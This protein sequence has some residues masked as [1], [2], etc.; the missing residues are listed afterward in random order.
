MLNKDL[1]TPKPIAL[2]DCRLVLSLHHLAGSSLAPRIL[3]ALDWPAASDLRS[4]AHLALLVP[5]PQLRLLP[6]DAAHMVAFVPSFASAAVL[7]APAVALLQQLPLHD[8]HA[9]QAYAGAVTALDQLGLLVALPAV[10]LPT[11]PASEVLTA[12]MHLTNA[13]NL[14]CTYCYIEK[15]AERMDVATARLALDAVVRAAIRYGYPEIALKY[16]GGEPLLALD[17]LETLHRYAQERTAEADLGL[18]AVV[19]S[20][21]LALSDA[22]VARLCDLD[23]GLTVSLD[24]L[25]SA[26]D[27]QRPTCGGGPSA[28]RVRAGLLRAQV[29]GLAPSAAITVSAASAAALPNLAE[30]LLAQDIPF[31][32]SFARG[33]GCGGYGVDPVAEGEQIIAAMRE[34]Y[35]V[36]AHHPPRWSVLGALIDRSDLSHPHSHACAV[37]ES[38]LVIDPHGQVAKCQM[39]IAQPVSTI[40]ASDPLGDLRHDPQGVQRIPV[41]VKHECRTCE[42]RYWCSGGCPIA[43]YQAT[44]RYD[45]KSP[46]CGIY[47]ALYPDL[48]RLEGLRLLHW[49]GR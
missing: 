4:L 15:S 10:D 17:T 16:A 28:A 9:L 30:W 24:G 42:W 36:V 34:L 2:N 14:R 5:H 47:K 11:P 1:Q 38:Y 44:G 26:H 12:W 43:T 6:L 45:L 27:V 19:L 18:Q 23:V 13:C 3:T 49:S 22:T 7:N 8:V 33:T 31:T 48:L 46:N 41:D 21:G 37:G 25:E 29:G 39:Q 35:T 40:H 32:V 20:N